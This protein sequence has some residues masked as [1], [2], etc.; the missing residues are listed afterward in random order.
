MLNVGQTWIG[1]GRVDFLPFM[2]ALHGGVCLIAVL[3]LFV[4][5]QNWSWRFLVPARPRLHKESA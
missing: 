2:V 5:H 1:T 3:W 4:R